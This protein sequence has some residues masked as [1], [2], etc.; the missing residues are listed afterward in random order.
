MI[1][2]EKNLAARLYG[3]AMVACFDLGGAE[4]EEERDVVEKAINNARRALR[5]KGYD[6]PALSSLQACMAAALAPASPQPPL[7]MSMFAS[8]ADYQA[9]LASRVAEDEEE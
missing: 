2:K 4:T 5:R 3:L 8:V 1:A 9:A 6:W 7:S